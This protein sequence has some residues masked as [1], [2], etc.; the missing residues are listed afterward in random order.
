M[1]EYL[2][3]QITGLYTNNQ[4]VEVV[5]YAADF[6]KINR[7]QSAIRNVRGVKNLNLSSYE[8][9]RAV[10]TV[11]YS[12]SPQTLYNQINSQSDL[13]L[14]LQSISYNTLTITVR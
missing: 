10:F 6:S 14:V 2:V 4:G 9:G 12:G 5:V 1:G 7:V 11:M 13:N 3:E 8:G